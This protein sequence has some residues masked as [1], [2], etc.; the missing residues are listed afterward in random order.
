[1]TLSLQDK[2]DQINDHARP[3]LYELLQ[4]W[5]PR[6]RMVSKTE[7]GV[8]NL[9]G[10]EGESLSINIKT[11][12]WKEFAG[13]P[14]GHEPLSLYAH[15]FCQGDRNKAFKE[16]RAKFHLSDDTP[17]PRRANGRANLKL[18]KADEWKPL[19]LPDPPPPY[20]KETGGWDHLF[21]YRTMGG[22]LL[23]Y[24]ARIDAKGDEPK[25]IRAITYGELNGRVGWHV[26]QPDAPR[27]LYGLERLG[28]AT[29]LLLEGELKA[30]LVQAVVGTAYGCLSI[31]GGTG[32]IEQ[33]DL[34][35][36]VG[37]LV[38]VC[39]DADAPGRK[40]A[41]RAGELL[42]AIGCAVQLVDMTGMPPKWDLADAVKEGWDAK[43]IM[44]FIE[45]RSRPDFDEADGDVDAD[46]DLGEPETERP[47]QKGEDP[48]DYGS[49]REGIVPLGHDKG[50][51]YYLS[52][53]TGQVHGLTASRHVELELTVLADPDAYWYRIKMLQNDEGEI[54]WKK[55]ARWLLRAC[56]S[57]GIYKPEKIRGRG[58]WM[59]GDHA[60]LHL[61][62]QLII[63]GVAQQSL[64]VDGS[65]YVYEAAHSLGQG[66]SDPLRA[67]DAN[68]LLQMC[69]LLRWEKQISAT[70]AAGW[71]AIA[72][73]CG[74]LHW[75]PSIWLT[76]G[77]N[78]GKTTFLGEIIGPILGRGV[79]DGIALN[80]QS[81]TTE[82]GLR[83]Q[84]GSDARPVIFDEAEAELLADKVRMQGNI[85]LVR[86]SSSEGGAEIIKGSQNQSGAKRYRIR[87]CFLFSSIN[88]SLSHLADESRIMVLDLYNPPVHELERDRQRW[89][90]LLALMAETV[91]HPEWCAGLVARS[92]RL[93]HVI[94]ANA[95]TFKLAVMEKLGN[96]RAGDQL[97]TLLAGAVS[98]HS[99][100]AITLEEAKAY[101]ERKETDE[102]WDWGHATAADAMKDEERL[103]ARLMQQKLR[104]EGDGRA[105]DRT[106]AELIAMAHTE[107]H[108]GPQDVKNPEP[109][110]LLKRNGI[111]FAAEFWDTDRPMDDGVWISN[112]HESITSWL[113]DTPWSTGWNRALR[114][115]PGA[116]S[117]DKKSI[118][119][120]KFDKTKAVFVPLSMLGDD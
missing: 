5:F 45:A 21:A 29:I 28:K 96:S 40:A 93:M 97:G 51:F 24:V 32:Q 23:R 88:V 25:K 34:S 86:Q 50:I 30:D 57:V 26:R 66:V 20:A 89:S 6:G 115:L 107:S 46:V 65:R 17:P 56:K 10:D 112:T 61:G 118:K 110:A 76:G 119:F 87:S 80:V 73:I 84:L 90:D 116:V 60:I 68:K 42:R 4:E 62:E 54:N 91:H 74:V 49:N 9:N 64:K 111:A 106:V 95:A 19:P 14:G 11:G 77:S 44:E 104:Y 94:R 33:N 27:C 105:V 37:C 99:D 58:A 18:V 16:L 15:A 43:R 55:A 103:L 47:E 48:Q 70:L 69:Q 72:P 98:L 109:A 31:T 114:R 36:L 2:F 41:A 38:I 7:Y 3:I 101:L 39:F 75:R 82:P 120:T 67:S 63:D 102:G 8:A 108:K 81:K 12:K 52:R 117:S 13:G 71:I 92:V 79:D 35:A 22:K 100:R 85:D 53:G 113:K 78:S 1:V 59:D 83:Q